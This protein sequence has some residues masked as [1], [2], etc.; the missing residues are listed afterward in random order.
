MNVRS[1]C[2]WRGHEFEIGIIIGDSANVTYLGGKF[3]EVC[4]LPGMSRPDKYEVI[5]EIPVA[6]LTNVVEQIDEVPLG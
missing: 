5:G 2:S 4:R 3:D 6:E 1:T